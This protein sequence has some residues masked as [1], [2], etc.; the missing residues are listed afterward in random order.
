MSSGRAKL[1]DVAGKA[2]VSLSTASKAL[3]NSQDV[4][5]E[6]RLRIRKI[7]KDL[8]FAPNALIRSL[9][10]GTS[11]TIGICTWAVSVVPAT[12][13]IAYNLL[14]GIADEVT[15]SRQDLLLYSDFLGKRDEDLVHVFMDGRVDGVIVGPHVLNQYG[16]EELVRAGIPAVVLYNENAPAKMSK[17]TIDNRSGILAVMRH[18]YDLGHTRIAFT[19][20][21]NTFDYQARYSAYLYS[22]S[23][24]G[25]QTPPAFHIGEESTPAT[26][27]RVLDEWAQTEMP[28]AIVAG[29]DSIAMKWIDALTKRGLNVPEDISITGFDD[30]P[31]AAS[32]PGL[33][34]I[35][36]DAEAV[37]R[38]AVMFVNAILLSTDPQ[39]QHIMLPVELVVRNSAKRLN[40]K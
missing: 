4:A 29:D 23:V 11:N 37:G 17:V 12:H 34:T 2:G 36:Q 22:M 24:L 13:S 5:E 6:T 14:K 33:T 21:Q 7:A 1:K 30:A 39:P 28:T 3:N 15:E 16:L 38:H 32:S 18:L 8:H 40:Q 20:P 10:R 19:A 9:Q 26:I 25:I 27:N 31:G 35:R